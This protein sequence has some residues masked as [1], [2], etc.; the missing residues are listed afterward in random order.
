MSISI[1]SQV[2][3]I[4]RLIRRR[5]CPTRIL[6]KYFQKTKT[7]DHITYQGVFK[8]FD[9][10]RKTLHFQTGYLS[11]DYLDTESRKVS[12]IV[13]HRNTEYEGNYRHRDLLLL[14]AGMPEN[15]I[16]IL[17][18][19][20]GFGL[21]FYYLITNLRKTIEYTAVD[22][23]EVNSIANKY[24]AQYSNFHTS[25]IKSLDSQKYDIINFGSSLQYIEDYQ[26]A[27]FDVLEKKPN[28]I[29][30]AD[31]PVGKKE[32]FATLQVNMKDRKIIRWIFSL[33]E[34][35]EIFNEHDYRLVGSTKV[36]WH[37]D[38]HNFLNFPEE[39]HHIEHLNLIFQKN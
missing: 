39:F 29:F 32:T 27:L 1:K 28:T 37:N 25:N 5:F 34:L 33:S 38:I 35:K 16:H 21:T 31:T 30:I 4:K 12:E 15:D 24:F 22:L 19:G 10:A 8:S 6:I 20:S 13:W 2:K 23:P 7:Q 9:D 26:A 11:K 18:V 14:L 3:S 17:D 36:D